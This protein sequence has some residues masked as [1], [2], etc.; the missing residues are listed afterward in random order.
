[1]GMLGATGVVGFTATGVATAE[2]SCFSMSMVLECQAL[3]LD[4]IRSFAVAEDF[5]K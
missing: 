2:G 5:Q 3:L 1:M 4:K